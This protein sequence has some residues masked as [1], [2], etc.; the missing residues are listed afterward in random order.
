[1]RLEADRIYVHDG[2]FWTSAGITAGIDLALALI[3]EDLGEAIARRTAQQLVVYYRRPGG[4]S[5]FSPLL[6]LERGEGRFT[7][8]LDHV[9]QHLVL[10]HDVDSLARHCAMS[11][12]HFARRF[13][14]EVGVSPAR[15]VERIRVDAARARLARVGESVQVVAVAAGFGNAERMRRSFVRLLG[16]APA[17]VRREARR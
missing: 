13:K 8:L 15:A 2:R 11:P 4:Q 16:V 12:R 5:Q 6:E 1:V 17:A 9:R 10:E 14:A 3:A 7:A